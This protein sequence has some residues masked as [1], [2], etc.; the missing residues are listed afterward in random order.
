MQTYEMNIKNELYRKNVLEMSVREEAEVY[1]MMNK[2]VDKL[3]Y[4]SGRSLDEARFC[5]FRALKN[6]FIIE[7]TYRVALSG[8]EFLT[9]M[10]K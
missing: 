6:V 10:E 4:E 2:A 8:L 9:R 5:F 1:D 3:E 7:S